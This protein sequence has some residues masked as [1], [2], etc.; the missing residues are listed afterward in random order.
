MYTPPYN[1]RHALQAERERVLDQAVRNLSRAYLPDRR[2]VM[3]TW[4]DRADNP[5]EWSWCATPI[6]DEFARLWAER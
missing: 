5:A 6:K 3:E 4:I 1:W 2:S